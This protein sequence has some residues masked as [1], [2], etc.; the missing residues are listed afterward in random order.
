MK[1]VI[2]AGGRG[3][4]L[5][6]MTKATNKHLLPVGQEPMIYHAVHRLEEADIKE[7]LI[8]TSTEHMG[9]IVRCLGSGEELGVSFTYK[10]QEKPLGIAHALALAENF[11]GGEKICVVLGDNVFLESIIELVK[12]Y[13][14]QEKGARVAL[15][16]VSDPE[17]FGVAAL[18]EKQVIEIE[19]KPSKPKSDYAVI[20][21][22]FYDSMVFDIIRGLEYS[23][24]GELEITA[25][26]NTYIARSLL[27]FDIFEG[28]WMDAGTPESLFQANRLFFERR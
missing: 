6:P 17:R 25:V 23:E 13:H 2:L 19:E 10:V 24:R 22:Y 9:D 18:D 7:I 26:N 11:A 4:R 14:H 8:V 3:M 28:P 1:G 21:L 12:N 16:K 15:R 27:E 5:H 20:G